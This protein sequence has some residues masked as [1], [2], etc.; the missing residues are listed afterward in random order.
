MSTERV[1]EIEDEAGEWLIRRDSG[2]WTE[3][4]HARF[5]QWLSASTLNRVSY[6]RLEATWEETARLKALGAG[7]HSDQPP[8][9]GQWNLGPFFE[10]RAL[11]D[12][13]TP[14]DNEQGKA[15]HHWSRL[16]AAAAALLLVVGMTLH[17]A[18]RS[19]GERY[20][21]PIGGIASVPIIDGSKVML[22]TDS[23]IRVAL[24][25]TERTIELQQ[26]EAFFDVAKDLKRPFV[27]S[28]G[29]SRVT[30]IGTQFAVR[31]DSND[32]QVIVTEG[33]VRVEGR[34]EALLM[35]G[36][37]AHL[38]DAGIR[39]QHSTVSE[40]EERI[41]WR[42]GM[43]MFRDRTLAEVTAEFNRYNRRKII[44]DDPVIGAL[45]I[46][47]NFRATNVESFVRVLEM[48]FPIRATAEQDRIVIT[49]R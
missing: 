25:S 11:G 13:S 31:R 17:F 19:E 28:A 29:G 46:E 38:S 44:I 32:L 26:G 41:G 37:V 36:D 33:E 42:L 18:L 15:R 14:R 8:P 21:T 34:G 40:A 3:N 20:M 49:S 27:V 6:L 5:E 47:G 24:S 45:K 10:S 39:V 12:V 22:N 30:A 4:E 9:P 7:I 2:D 43:L 23:Q 16:F 35:P 48:S 1:N